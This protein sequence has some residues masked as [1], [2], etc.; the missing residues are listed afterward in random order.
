MKRAIAAAVTLVIVAGLGADGNCQTPFRKLGRGIVNAVTCPAELPKAIFK[1]AED[2][3]PVDALFLG[4]PRGIGM[5]ALRA[6]TS[7]IE[8]ITFPFRIP[9]VGYDPIIKPEFCWQEEL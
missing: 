4:I 2:R 1:T 9:S 5:M 8:V 7:S 3:G 6:V